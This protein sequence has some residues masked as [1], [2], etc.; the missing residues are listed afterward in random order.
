MVMDGC[1]VQLFGCADESVAGVV[2][3]DVQPAERIDGSI[4]DP[5]DLAALA[6]VQVQDTQGGWILLRE[7]GQC[8]VAADGA[9]DL[10]ASFQRCFGEGA[11]QAA[12]CAG[13]EP[14]TRGRWGGHG[15]PCSRSGET[16]RLAD[17]PIV[18]SASTR[19]GVSQSG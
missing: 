10:V 8:V 4:D 18:R 14:H 7:I 13:H 19:R 11:P 12:T 1:L 16:L 6:D 3:D 5:Q 17:E 9:D 2:D 15:S